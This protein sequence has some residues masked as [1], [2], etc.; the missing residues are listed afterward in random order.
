MRREDK[1]IRDL[2]IIEW[3]LTKAHVGR[4]ALI[5]KN[6]PYI[7]PVNFGYRDNA[8]YFHSA[9]E[10]RKINILKKNN[11]VCFQT[12]VRHELVKNDVACRWSAKF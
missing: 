2:E 10:G 1:E 3:I 12:E 7:V 4:I 8:I 9:N 11:S 5:D 6:Q